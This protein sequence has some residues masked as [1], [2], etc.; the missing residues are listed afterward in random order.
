MC[1]QEQ[2]WPS[3]V[4]HDRESGDKSRDG[5][6][7]LVVVESPAHSKDQQGQDQEE[8]GS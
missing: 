1:K 4:G 8:N 7:Q 5:S 6:V 3:Q 2:A